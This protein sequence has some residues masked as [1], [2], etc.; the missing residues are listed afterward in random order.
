[1]D[2]SQSNRFNIFNSQNEYF[3]SMNVCA[4]LCVHQSVF[5]LN[6]SFSI[7][8]RATLL[9]FSVSVNFYLFFAYEV[10]LEFL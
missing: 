7:F 1:M 6:Y 9:S 10:A 5:C 2:L 8:S 3:S 4:A